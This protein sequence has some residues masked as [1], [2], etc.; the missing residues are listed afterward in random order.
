MS[1][2]VSGR[3]QS[4]RPQK[5]CNEANTA[6]NVLAILEYLAHNDLM[7]GVRDKA[8]EV[9]DDDAKQRINTSTISF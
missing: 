1:I 8:Q 5:C 2:F 9:L 7:M 4:N 6:K 3:Q